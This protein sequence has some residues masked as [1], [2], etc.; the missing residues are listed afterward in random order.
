MKILIISGSHSRHLFVHESILKSGADCA[1][2]VMERESAIPFPPVNIAKHDRQNFKNHFEER[3]RVEK[4][5]YGEIKPKEIFD[6]IPTMYCTAESLNS[7]NVT[8][9]A[10]KFSPD[11]VFIFGPDLI[12]NPLLNVLPV[13]RINLHLGLSPWFRGSATLF[14][15]FYFLQP[16]F[17]G[18]TF[19]QILPEA[20]AG[21]ILHQCRP[22]LEIGDGIHDVGVKVVIQAKNDLIGLIDSC[23][24]NES[25]SYSKQKSTGRLFLTSDFEP[26]HLRV[27]YDTFQNKI[28]DSYLNGE[29]G[30][31][32][33]NL[34]SYFE[35]K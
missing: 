2:V 3:S 26:S 32:I 30:R 13:N 9:F 1:A 16:Q 20:D 35:H 6:G 33:P 22:K 15:P 11:M 7:I 21:D 31:K 25:L 27:I 19:H 29:L 17:A 24:T 14:W 4:K 28:V 12:R 23:M 34:I 10:K 8:N 18:S 5:A